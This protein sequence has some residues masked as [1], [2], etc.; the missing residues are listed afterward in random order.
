MSKIVKAIPLIM[1]T[2]VLLVMGCQP[3]SEPPTT[4]SSTGPLKGNLAPDFQ[5]QDFDGQTISLSNLRGKPV[6]LNFWATWC[7]PCVHEMPFIQQIYEEW[8]GKGLVLLTINVRETSSK[9]KAFMKSHDLS[10][11]VLLDT[12]GSVADKYY[13]RG[14]PT[15]FLI[16][17]DGLIAGYKVGAFQSKEEIEAGIREVLP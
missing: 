17:K 1:L 11:P 5:L 7:G 2:S 6:L 16:D 12:R 3:L 8:S 14:I 10:F 15:T 4:T 13:I 9:A